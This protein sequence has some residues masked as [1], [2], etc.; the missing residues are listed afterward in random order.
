MSQK[1]SA[2][3]LIELLVVIVIIGILATIG[4]AQFNEYQEKA[5]MAKAQAF[6]S[7]AKRVLDLGLERTVG[8]WDF[9]EGAGINA[10]DKSGRNNDFPLTGGTYVNESFHEN[11]RSS[12]ENDANY[13]VLYPKVT[14]LD[15]NA[16]TMAAWIRLDEENATTANTISVAPFGVGYLYEGLEYSVSIGYWDDGTDLRIRHLRWNTMPFR[17]VDQK[18]YYHLITMRALGGELCE[19]KTYLDGDLVSHSSQISCPD[20]IIDVDRVSIGSNIEVD[21]LGVWNVW[22]DGS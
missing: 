22:Y 6:A 10:I 7:Q 8:F 3:T 15:N 13:R 18:W 1:K 12:F 4:V 2:F 16:V 11:A 20:S 9:N 17:I 19:F 21:D 5:R 14:N